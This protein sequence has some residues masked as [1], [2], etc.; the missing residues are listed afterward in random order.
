MLAEFKYGLEPKE[1]F[2]NQFNQAKSNRCVLSLS[3]KGNFLKCVRL[4]Y[5]FKK[6]LVQF[7]PGLLDLTL[8]STGSVP[9]GVLELYGGLWTNWHWLMLIEFQKVK[10]QWY[11]TNGPFRPKYA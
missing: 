4:F 8:I 9:M 11:G 10:G 7:L 2:A 6:V 3:G 5:H 1:T